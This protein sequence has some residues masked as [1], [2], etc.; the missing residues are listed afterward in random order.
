MIYIV[1]VIYA[2]AFEYYLNI[3]KY[4]KIIFK[5][6]ARMNFPKVRVNLPKASVIPKNK[7]EYEIHSKIEQIKRNSF[8]RQFHESIKSI[9]NIPEIPQ[10]TEEKPI[11]QKNSEY[12]N[13][14]YG[15]AG[16]IGEGGCGALAI[17]YALRCIGI[18]CDFKELIKEIDEQGYRAYKLDE[19]GSILSGDGTEYEIFEILAKELHSANEIFEYLQQSCP[20]T[21]LV[22]N[23]IY[24]SDINHKG[25]HFVTIVG[26][27]KNQNFVITDG[28]L[29]VD[30]PVLRKA[31]TM[32]QAIRGVWGWKKYKG[33]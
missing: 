28:N 22:K 31:S 29:D 12:S 17:E 30:K 20:V 32:F 9:K 21:A 10:I 25:N 3:I 13:I 18:K 19:Q 33:E 8:E 4:Y 27:D 24:H 11:S 23:N 5:E 7:E 15:K 16:T 14:V 6:K 2:V 1:E 26:I